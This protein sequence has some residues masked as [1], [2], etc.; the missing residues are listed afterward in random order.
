MA[1]YSVLPNQY[2]L[3]RLT[4]KQEKKKIKNFRLNVDQLKI[5]INSR[6]VSLLI[7]IILRL[8]L[9]YNK[10]KLYTKI[11]IY[12]LS[13]QPTNQVFSIKRLIY[14]KHIQKLLPFP[15]PSL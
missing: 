4:S 13:T 12:K 5:S 3:L 8:N 2:D 10:K 9:I 14:T 6:R 15:K 11:Y 1:A 7:F